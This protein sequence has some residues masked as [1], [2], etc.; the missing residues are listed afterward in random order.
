MLICRIFGTKND[1]WFFILIDDATMRP[2]SKAMQR[3]I[4]KCE[5]LKNVTDDSNYLLHSFT[6]ISIMLRQRLYTH[7]RHTSDGFMTITPTFLPLMTSCDDYLHEMFFY[8]GEFHYEIAKKLKY[9]CIEKETNLHLWP[10]MVYFAGK[11]AKYVDRE[12]KVRMD[13]THYLEKQLFRKSPWIY[14]IRDP[15]H[16]ILETESFSDD[17]GRADL[18]RQPPVAFLIVRP[19]QN[20]LFACGDIDK[21]LI[22]PTLTN[23]CLNFFFYSFCGKICAKILF[24]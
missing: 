18:I 6:L 3:I 8:S 14:V 16:D 10:Q 24:F 19:N 21:I 22:L 13:V 12:S 1:C 23:F 11:F 20:L 7:P 2:P 17:D 9:E 4:T 5:G 15:D